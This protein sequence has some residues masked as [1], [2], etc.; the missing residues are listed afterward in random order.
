LVS[1]NLSLSTPQNEISE[2]IDLESRCIIV[3]ERS[4]TVVKPFRFT[5]ADILLIAHTET[6]KATILTWKHFIE[7]L[8]MTMD[9]FNLGLY[10]SLNV[11]G[12]EVLQM[13]RG[14]NIVVM[15]D[16]FYSWGFGKKV[17]TDYIDTDEL[18]RLAT[19]GTKLLICDVEVRRTDEMRRWL[20]DIV[21]SNTGGETFTADELEGGESLWR[22]DVR[23]SLSKKRGRSTMLG[24]ETNVIRRLSKQFPSRRFAIV[25]QDDSTL[26]IRESLY[27]DTRISVTISPTTDISPLTRYTFISNLPFSSRLSL[28]SSLFL[29]TTT[30]I[31]MAEYLTLSIAHDISNE[32]RHSDSSLLD[33][34]LKFEPCRFDP[35]SIEFV[36]IILSSIS[37]GCNQ[38]KSGFTLSAEILGFLNAQYPAELV[39]AM[40]LRLRWSRALSLDDIREKIAVSCGIDV[41]DFGARVIHSGD[42]GSEVRQ[43]GAISRRM[44]RKEIESNCSRF[45][46]TFAAHMHELIKFTP[47]ARY[48][49]S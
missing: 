39:D 47:T 16:E 15:G 41:A 48:S 36:A 26:A 46:T 49:S 24:N 6:S 23:Q 1:I 11:N 43:D 7:N 20:S 19:L 44:T 38:R 33:Q 8:G 17:A 25:R 14:K 35:T 42:I 29:D 4:V 12:V 10:G 13:Y 45:E 21:H 5:R 40:I 3:V 34:F 18:A 37:N 22:R 27:F 30:N 32:Q 31:E 9:V 2:G 28:L